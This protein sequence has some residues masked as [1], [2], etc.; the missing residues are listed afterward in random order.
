MTSNPENALY[1]IMI[2]GTT[3]VTTTYQAPMFVSN[4]GYLNI[5]N[6]SEVQMSLPRDA[7]GNFFTTNTSQ[8]ESFLFVEESSG[9]T[10]QF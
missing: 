6:S 1:N 9:M 10:F 3:N 5:T 2:N 7:N 4:G 8:G